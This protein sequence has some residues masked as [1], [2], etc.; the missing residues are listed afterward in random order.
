MPEGKHS[1]STIVRPSTKHNLPKPPATILLHGLDR[2]PPI[3]IEIRHFYH[4]SHESSINNVIENLKD[5]LAE[6]LEFYLPVAGTVITDEDAENYILT[7]ATNIQGA[8]FIVEIKEEA[9]EKETEELSPRTGAFLP[10][11]SPTFAVKLTQVS[12]PICSQ[13]CM[14]D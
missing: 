3:H 4:I 13:K 11:G 8:L 6:A 14:T 2:A 12:S 7:D 1:E 9:F 5:S 10:P